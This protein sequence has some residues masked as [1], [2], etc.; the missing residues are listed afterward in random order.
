MTQFKKY[1]LGELCTD[2]SYGYTESAKLEKIGPK[3]LRITDIQNDHIDW[4]SVPYCPISD[5]DYKKY[6]LEIGDIVIARTGNSTGA[7]STIK[8]DIEAVFASYLIRF[9]LD[10]EIANPFYVDFVLRS[11]LWQNFVESIKGGS[12]QPDANAKQLAEFEFDLPGLPTQTRIASILSSL[13]DKIE[14]NRRTNHTLEQIAQT[15]FK[16]YFVEDIDPENLPEGWGWGTLR[17]HIKI[18]N[19]FAFKGTDFIESG[20]PVLKIKNVKAGKILLSTLSYVSKEVAGKAN[21]YTVK[22]NDLLVTMTG[23]RL[24]GTPETW[25][26]KVALFHK[27]AGYLLNQRVSIMNVINDEV[28]SRYYLCQLL[29]TEEMQYYFASNATSS[30][31]QANISP[32]LIYDTEVLV[33]PHSV[34]KLFNSIAKEVYD[35]MSVN[36]AEIESLSKIRDSLLPKLMS[37]E[38]EV[39]VAEKELVN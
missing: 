15:L 14:L 6:K 8:D 27:N 26:G 18:K 32:D 29:T 24:D 7:T 23:N 21:G 34:M 1:K 35:K 30:G 28:L 13:D 9:R 33:P 3:F 2:V 12:A 17:S 4:N 39:N 19:G 11:I 22:K 36:E 31:G 25:V 10:K 5:S 20:V 16:K 38:I 37:G